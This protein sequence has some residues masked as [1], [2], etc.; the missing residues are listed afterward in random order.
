MRDHL[1]AGLS[2]LHELVKRYIT[3]RALV[4]K[5]EQDLEVVRTRCLSIR[6]D[7]EML[8]HR[9]ALQDV[10]TVDN[11]AQVN[12]VTTAVSN[13]MSFMSVM[14]DLMAGTLGRILDVAR[15]EYSTVYRSLAAFTDV[16]RA[17]RSTWPSYACPICM[18][19]CVDVFLSPCGHT[20]CAKCCPP[21]SDRCFVC[22][23][24]VARVHDLYFSS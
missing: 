24:H 20:Y 1:G 4:E 8:Q 5:V 18:S 7:I 22:R 12:D 10:Q 16:Y 17:A 9:V 6:T 21:I 23:M 13:V 15:G 2:R 11:V 19:D 3:L 14:E